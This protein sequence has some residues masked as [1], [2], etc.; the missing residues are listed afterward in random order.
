MP[1]PY[2]IT[3]DE[4]PENF[5]FEGYGPVN[6]D[7]PSYS[8]VTHDPCEAVR[9]LDAVQEA[10]KKG[11]TGDSKRAYDDMVRWCSK[12]GGGEQAKPP[13]TPPPVDNPSTTGADA[14]PPADGETAESLG[15]PDP[16][17][18]NSAQSTPAA[19]GQSDG[20][21]LQEQYRDPQSPMPEYDV[22]SNLESQGVPRSQIAGETQ[23]VVRNDP[24]TARAHPI[25][26]KDDTQ[27]GV[28][29]VDPVDVF[30]GQ[31]SLTVTDVEIASRGIPLRL[32][33]M[34]RSGEAY[35]GPWGYN[36]DHN[37]NVYVRELENGGVAVWTGRLSEDV[38]GVGP[39]FEPPTAVFRRLEF[40]A[41]TP[42][43]GNRYVITER[44]G[45]RF[46]FERPAGWADPERIPLVRIEDRHG[47]AHG[48]T[49]DAH[50]RLAVV[51]D[52]AG[53][54]IEFAYGD[55]GLLEEVRDHTGRRWLYRHDDPA[56]HLIGVTTPPTP[57]YPDGL[58]TTYE[59]DVFRTHPALIHNLTALRDPTGQIVVE[60]VYGDDPTS[61]DFARVV[62]QRF[63][64][65]EATFHATLLQLVPR[66]PDAINVPALRVEVVDPGVLH[67]Y[68]FNYRGDLL[69]ERFRL[70]ADGSYRLVAKTY[71]YDEQG[72]LVERREPD[73]RGAIARFDDSN[74]DPCARGNLL[75]LTEVASV[76]APAPGRDVLRATYE[77]RYQLLKTSRDARGNLTRYIYDYEVY[78]TGT[79]CLVQIR[80]PQVTLPD[81]VVQNAVENFTYNGAGQLLTHVEAAGTH[82]FDYQPTGPAVGF[83][84]RREHTVGTSL[85]REEFE[86]DG[87]GNLVA[88]ID[89]VGNRTEYDVDA[90]GRPTRVDEP[91][92]A[93]WEFEYDRTG[94]LAAALEPRGDYDDAVLGGNAIRHEFAYD[95]LGYLE[96]EV[97]AV[98]TVARRRFT[99]TRNAEGVALEARDPLGRVVR[100][101][102]DERG[103]VLEEELLDAAGASSYRRMQTWSRAGDLLQVRL[104]D[105]APMDIGYDGFGA[106]RVVTAPDGSKL[107]YG[108]EQ[109]GLVERVE[110]EGI[111]TPG[112]VPVLLSRRRFDLDARGHVRRSIDEVFTPGGAGSVD[113][114]TSYF[115]DGSGRP[116]RIE[117]PT[118][119]I[120]R[121]T[122]SATGV[123]L[124]ERDSLG[125]SVTWDLDLAGRARTTT[126]A[127]AGPAGAV[128]AV[129]ARDYDARG[130]VIFDDDP[131]GNRTSYSYDERGLLRSATNSVGETLDFTY[132][133]HRDELS[134][135]TGGATVQLDRDSGGRIVRL[136]DP[137]GIESRFDRDAQDRIVRILR[138]DGR[139]Q[140]F[141]FNSAGAAKQF[142][143]FDGTQLDYTN[144]PLNLPE[145]IVS[146]PAG[147][148]APTPVTE[149]SYDGARRIVRAASGGIAQSFRYDSLGRLLEDGGPDR[150]RVS[151]DAP[152]RVCRVEYP[153]GRRD[154]R[155]LDELFRLTS[156]VLE[157]EGSVGLTGH[158]LPVGTVLAAVEWAGV[159]RPERLASGSTFA[160][161]RYDDAL[162][163]CELH[164]EDAGGAALR[165]EAWVR[166]PLGLRRADRKRSPRVEEASYAYDGMS[167]LDLARLGLP[168]GTVPAATAGLNQ[169]AMDAV[170]AAAAAAPAARVS[171]FNYAPGDTPAARVERDAV[172]TVVSRRAFTDNALHQ[173]TSADLVPITYD[174]AGNIRTY[175]SRAYTYDAFRRLVEVRDSGVRVAAFAYDG[176]GRL[177][178]RS[179]QAG[180]RRFAYLG[181]ELLQESDG[182]SVVFQYT[183][184]PRLD[185][186]LLASGSAGSF[187]LLWDGIGSL[188]AASDPSGAVLERYGYD[189][190]GRPTVLAPDGVTVRPAS[191]IGLEPRFQGRPYYAA[192]DLF[193]FR[194]RFYHPDLFVFL[195]PDPFAFAD[196]WCPYAFVRY[197]P[198]NFADPYG[199]WAQ[200]VLGAVVGAA[201]G[202]VGAALSGGDWADV[203]VGIAAGGIGGGITAA[204]LNPALGGAVAGGLMGAWSGGRVGYKAGGAGGAVLGGLAGGTIGAGIG[205]ATGFIGGKIGNSSATAA[206][207]VINRTLTSAG[208]RAT[209]SGTAARY[210]GMVAGGYIGGST[211]GVFGNVTATVTV[212]VITDRPVTG[213]QLWNATYH[214]LVIDGPLGAAGAT[215]D[216]FIMIS[217]FPGTRSNVFGAEGEA[218]VGQYYRLEPANGRQR[219]WMIDTRQERRPDYFTEETIPELGAVL[220]IKN[221]QAVD[222]DDLAQ[223]A[224]F[225]D[226]ATQL[227]GEL[228]VFVRPG[229]RTNNLPPA[230]NM[231]VLPIPQQPLVV[232]VPVP[233]SQAPK[234][235]K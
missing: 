119:L 200:I 172:G 127:E 190:L 174:E 23:R 155:E 59:Y 129:F 64:E 16:K 9:F 26:G 130:R 234:P 193:D 87:V 14:P 211:A 136:V 192:A 218:L 217:R 8:F 66:T 99:Y 216:R 65:F 73:G 152:G 131:L 182:G 83:L 210:G 185:Q 35:F 178:R 39:T 146:T 3:S 235:D 153:D 106:I 47:N 202:G 175:G 61:E 72:N 141:R 117:E 1:E 156:D 209:V 134:Y 50:G 128:Q 201:M 223:I 138:A 150:V 169:P 176:L 195:Q 109:R 101:R 158:G 194:D 110:L 125:N 28:T 52:H 114:T 140:R 111:A 145:R 92:G 48:L 97:H 12:K 189:L 166:D 144:S 214:G 206:N 89:G 84:R 98:N 77:S 163:L 60:N 228:W 184:G 215:A 230:T 149:L 112:G 139:E 186:P 199:R 5:T 115:L 32:T 224:D 85:F 82:T 121:R 70:V 42:L 90:L 51:S 4:P 151:Y 20:R 116:E 231:R 105:G 43:H 229:M 91:D 107:R 220:E 154:R 160:E 183:S 10:N 123:L 88:R 197:N 34:Y 15:A 102:V 6:L 22:A 56:E 33:R 113:S 18:A 46:F 45:I 49:Y 58:T 196:G 68:T 104:A 171:D 103:L 212:D 126:L 25:H 67:V 29:T 7:G 79:G 168:A 208:V 205:A 80:H 40:E 94:R 132:D 188:A 75:R 108:R 27:R 11:F 76:V 181:S 19:P 124:E 118:G 177:H 54:R 165:D 203:L 2:T 227:G 24:P 157:V 207:W 53:R 232:S 148:A 69:D 93:V 86:H 21:T 159:T 222:T 31:Y 38:Y 198:L 187:A 180:S 81:G 143:D 55:C 133:A 164:H 96:A 191:T 78:P 37:Y 13:P 226:L 137:A 100:R 167:R 179:D 71:R 135:A 219:V 213:Q 170:A 57:G 30:G 44:E 41:A 95:R 221:K 36:W 161:L 142:V 162:R 63:G 120:R 62:E 225:R 122:Y 204:T 147:A 74:P 17:P 233:F 173:L